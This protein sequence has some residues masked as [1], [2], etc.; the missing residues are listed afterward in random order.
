MEDTTE[1]VFT[2]LTQWFYTQKLDG[3]LG[4]ASVAGDKLARLW[5]LAERLLIPRLQNLAIDRIDEKRIECKFIYTTALQH[6]WDSTAHDSPLRRLFIQQCAWNINADVY[7]SSIDRFP[8][9]MLAEIC[10][11]FRENA[12]SDAK[13][14]RNMAD[15]HVKED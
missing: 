2:L 6:V 5:V 10:F 11:L 12:K 3:D 14:S 1:G 8:K 15:F 7:R 13:A 9:Q 4:G